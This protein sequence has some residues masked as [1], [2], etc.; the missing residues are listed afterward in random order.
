METFTE[1]L[2]RWTTSST[3][4]PEY[5]WTKSKSPHN[6]KAQAVY[7]H[8]WH[9]MEQSIITAEVRQALILLEDKREEFKALAKESE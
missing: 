6:Q 7:L 9:N 2:R 3:T 8:F 5:P 4:Y 1:R